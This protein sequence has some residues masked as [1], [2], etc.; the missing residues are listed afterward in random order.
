MKKVEQS[1]YVKAGLLFLNSRGR[2]L[3]DVK[4]LPDCEVDI[5]IKKKGKATSAQRRYYF[6]V[7]VHEI[8]RRM[9]ELGNDVDKDIVH[10]Y[11]KSEFNKQPIHDAEGVVIGYV[12]GTTTEHNVEDRIEYIDKCIHFADTVLDIVIPPPSTQSEMFPE[13]NSKVMVAEFDNDVKAT[14]VA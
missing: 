11:L 8:T 1:G 6:G 10:E 2:F 4:Q 9:I 7:I 5:I 13:Y 12:G 3:E 14:I